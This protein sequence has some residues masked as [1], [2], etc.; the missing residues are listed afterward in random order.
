VTSGT[1][2][3]K[4]LFKHLAGVVAAVKSIDAVSPSRSHRSVIRQISAIIG[5]RCWTTVPTNPCSTIAFNNQAKCAIIS[6]RSSISVLRALTIMHPVMAI[7]MMGIVLAICANDVVVVWVMLMIRM[8]LLFDS[9]S[10]L[11]SIQVQY[12]H[13][14]QGRWDAIRVRPY[15]GRSRGPCSRWVLS[16]FPLQVYHGRGI[17]QQLHSAELIPIRLSQW[18]M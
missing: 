10:M 3:I 16:E 15:I 14:I 12:R 4:V 5:A 6:Y 11:V 7:T 8:T 13:G 17:S 1:A 9:H 18:V 2:L